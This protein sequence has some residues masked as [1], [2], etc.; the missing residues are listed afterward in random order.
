[1]LRDI[2]PFHIAGGLYYVGDSMDSSH[3]LDTGAGLLLIDTPRDPDS[4]EIIRENMEKLGFSVS[5][6]RYIIVSHGHFDHFAG[7]PKLVEW[8][9]AETFLGEKDLALKPNFVP[10]HLLHDGDEITLGDTTIRCLHTPGHT[11][12]TMSFFFELH[13]AG[14]TFRAAM[15]GGAGI[16][17]MSKRYLDKHGLYYHQRGDFY[18]SLERLRGEQVDICVGNHPRP[19]KLFD[20]Q[21]RAATEGFRAFVDPTQWRRFLDRRE[22]LLDQLISKEQQELFVNYAHR[23]ASTYCPENTMLAFYTGVYMGANGIETD[24]RLTKDGVAVLFHDETMERITDG[25]GKLC[26]HTYEQLQELWV[27][28]GQLRDKIPTLEDFLAH[29]APMD[30]TYAIELKADGAEQITADLIRKYGMESK[31]IVTS[32]RFSRLE[33]LHSIAPE[34]KKGYLVKQYDEQTFDKMRAIGCDE[35]CP[36]ASLATEETVKDWHREGFRVRAWGVSNEAV[37][38]RLLAC[39]VDGMTVNFPDKLTAQLNK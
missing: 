17:Q 13:E 12:G 1:M 21:E 22:V 38:E 7:V 18:R 30:L 28:N 23:G 29:F 26:D 25:E 19:I 31:C 33:K 36:L 14:E 27:M 2:T 15:F 20:K 11:V 5:D 9:G 16:D 10:D 3:L 6:I 8:S 34:L 4:A 37:M 24:V 32:F 39:G 35:F